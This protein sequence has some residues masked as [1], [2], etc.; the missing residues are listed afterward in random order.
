MPK[1]HGPKAV[2]FSG[3][4]KVVQGFG[5][6]DQTVRMSLQRHPSFQ[7]QHWSLLQQRGRCH[8][9]YYGTF[10]TRRIWVAI[11]KGVTPRSAKRFT[12]VSVSPLSV[13]CKL[14]YRSIMPHESNLTPSKTC[15]ISK[16]SIR[17]IDRNC[18]KFDWQF[19]TQFTFWKGYQPQKANTVGAVS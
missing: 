3:G 2:R 19:A 7:Q 15:I 4:H 14:S 9:T 11:A 12:S 10:A 8:R 1:S 5:M 13:I 18:V 16:K 17:Q 6:L